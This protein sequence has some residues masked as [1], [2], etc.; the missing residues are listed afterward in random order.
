[1]KCSKRRM[2][3]QHLAA[4]AL[5]RAFSESL[6]GGFS[7]KHDVTHHHDAYP[8]PVRVYAEI[9]NFEGQIFRVPGFN[10]ARDQRDF[11]LQGVPIA[12]ITGRPEDAPLG[13]ASI[14]I[15]FEYDR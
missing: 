12:F 2:E 6:R 14:T 8:Q 11:S 10:L 13:Q 5:G 4:A 9:G 3:R 1:M 7:L 15:R